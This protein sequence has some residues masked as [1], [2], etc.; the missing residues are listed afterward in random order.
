VV[1][2]GFFVN[3]HEGM[4]SI[5]EILPKLQKTM[6]EYE[7]GNVNLILGEFCEPNQYDARKKY[8]TDSLNI[9]N[10]IGVYHEQGSVL[11]AL[12]EHAA[13]ESNYEQAIDYCEKACML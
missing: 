10:K 8:L 6:D 4:R 3:F 11:Q 1:D 7:W 9:F 13:I 12:G 2:Y 5:H